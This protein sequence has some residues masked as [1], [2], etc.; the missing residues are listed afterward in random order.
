[1]PV[2]LYG[3]QLS[4]Y[5]VSSVTDYLIE[6]L[7]KQKQTIWDHAKSIYDTDKEMYHFMS[8]YVSALNLHLS[9]LKGATLRPDSVRE[10]H[11]KDEPAEL[12]QVLEDLSSDIH[13]SILD[14]IAIEKQ[15]NH[16]DNT[17][18]PQAIYDKITSFHP[19]L[20][21]KVSDIVPQFSYR[22]KEAY[23]EAMSNIGANPVSDVPKKKETDEN[24]NSVGSDS[25]KVKETNV[26]SLAVKLSMENNQK[27]STVKRTAPQKEKQLQEEPALSG[28]LDQF[29]ASAK[30]AM[31]TWKNS[32]E[33]KKFIS[34]L[35]TLKTAAMA[36]EDPS[37]FGIDKDI[38]K[39]RYD[40][41][42]NRVRKSA[43]AYEEYR[44]KNR[45]ED[46]GKKERGKS[47]VNS[48][49]RRKLDLVRMTK[50]DNFPLSAPRML[51]EKSLLEKNNASKKM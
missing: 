49:D 40:T 13:N 33:Y 42:L 29:I 3:H 25:P 41:A 4:T 34:D 26:D 10:A 51:A 9:R 18:S 35:E 30:K 1:M 31:S 19:P 44:L 6:K 50:D 17:E 15:L 46:P 12:T 48:Q 14:K 5:D 11:I 20:N 7:E 36:L 39:Y 37:K 43:T 32:G 28:S 27:S 16:P 2:L 45:Y 38:L 47:L 24:I 23:E 8:G 21:F 22:I